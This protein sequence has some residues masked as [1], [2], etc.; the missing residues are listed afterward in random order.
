MKATG[1][2]AWRNSAP[3]HCRQLIVAEYYLLNGFSWRVNIKSMITEV[4]AALST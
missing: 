4:S 1:I 3:V 2:P